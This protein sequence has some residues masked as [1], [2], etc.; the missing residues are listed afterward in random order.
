M[1]STCAKVR[2]LWPVSDPYKMQHA[3]KRF[4]V[5][6]AKLAVPVDVQHVLGKVRF[7]QTTKTKS[8][9]EAAPR[10]ALLVAL[11]K[12]QIAKARSTLPDPAAT[13]WEGLRNDLISA[14][15]LGDYAT[16]D[17]IFELVQDAAEKLNDPEEGSRLFKFATDQQGTLLAPLVVAWKGSLRMA[18]KT[19]DQQHRDVLRVA[20]HFISLE[21]LC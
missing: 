9:S 13:F 4:H 3:E 1:C 2:L 16:E 14:K 21:A 11:W 19:I 20:E 12:S 10:V 7:F 8:S 17:A 18:Q 15:Q 6:Y 5:W